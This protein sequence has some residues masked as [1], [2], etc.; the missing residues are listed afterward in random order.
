MTGSMLLEKFWVTLF[1][2]KFNSSSNLEFYVIQKILTV[3]RFRIIGL[4]KMKYK[5]L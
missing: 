5:Q 2:L 3:I 4:L 1:Y